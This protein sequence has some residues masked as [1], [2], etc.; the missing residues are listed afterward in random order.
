MPTIKEAQLDLNNRDYALEVLS[1]Y[2]FGEVLNLRQA[3]VKDKVL[4][5]MVQNYIASDKAKQNE[6]IND[7]IYRWANS[8]QIDPNIKFVN[9]NLLVA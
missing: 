9:L 7:I 8:D 4:Q 2:T 3:M 5:T 1:Y 6:I